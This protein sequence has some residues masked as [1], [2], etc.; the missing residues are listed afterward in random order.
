LQEFLDVKNNFWRQAV[1]ESRG[2]IPYFYAK[3]RP[4]RPKKVFGDQAPSP[5]QGLDPALALASVHVL[6]LSEK[7]A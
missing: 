7:Y 3:L 2:G 4:E 1:F 5:S 6:F